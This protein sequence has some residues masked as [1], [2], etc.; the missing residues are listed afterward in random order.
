MV[1]PLRLNVRKYSVALYP[2][3]R[4]YACHTSK[5]GADFRTVT[6]KVV[7]N[8]N[9][10]NLWGIRNLSGSVWYVEMPDGSRKSVVPESVLPVFRKVKIDFGNAGPAEIV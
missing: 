7:R 8:R 3:N 5:D 4:L 6:G 10:P 9:N 2:G 1:R